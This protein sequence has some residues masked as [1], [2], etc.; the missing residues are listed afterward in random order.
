MDL[1]RTILL[2]STLAIIANSAPPTCY[3]AVLKLSKGIMV[4]MERF[5]KFPVTRQCLAHLP[6]L[7]INVHNACVTVK[8]RDHIYALENLIIPECRTLKR[9]SFLKFRIQRL[10]NMIDRLC[11][12]DLVFYIDDCPALERPPEPE[13]DIEK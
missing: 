1:L 3:S 13:E 11:Y 7:Y 6:K 9:I 5:E 8:L 12:R 2:L 10:Y 4:S